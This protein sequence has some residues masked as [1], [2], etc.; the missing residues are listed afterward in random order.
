MVYRLPQRPEDPDPGAYVVL[1][2][3]DTGC[4]MSEEVLAKA[5]EPF[6]T[7]KAVG[8]GSGLGLAQV[9]GFAKQSGGGVSIDTAENAGTTIKV[10]L[11]SIAQAATP[12]ISA[13]DMPGNA[14]ADDLHRTI[15]LVDDDPDVRSVTSMMLSSL[16]YSVVEAE[17]GD[18]ALRKIDPAI[19]LVLTDFAMPNM[20]GAELAE[21]VKRDHPGLPIMF[22][23]GFADIDILDV[24]QQLIVQKPY[25]EEEL[26]R[27]LANVFM[28]VGAG[29]GVAS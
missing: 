7:T 8:K 16:G 6:F 25:K 11:P 26:A 1:S 4:G 24:D 29:A 19:E 2:V 5:F 27:K 21:I 9:F 15:L 20:T 17:N 14:D 23:T 10:Y 28:K 18:D 3:K 22:I 12:V 13:S